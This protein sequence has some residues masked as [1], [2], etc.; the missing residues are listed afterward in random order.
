MLF[1]LVVGSTGW[2]VGSPLPSV[3]LRA[4]HSSLA[5]CLPCVRVLDAD[6]WEK[7]LAR[8]ANKT[9]HTFRFCCACRGQGMENI[10]K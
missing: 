5:S 2:V 4:H 9:L 10:R 6:G 1:L 3:L 8:L 7:L